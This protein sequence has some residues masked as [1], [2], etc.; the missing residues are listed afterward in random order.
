MDPTIQSLLDFGA[1]GAFAA[2]LVWMNNKL[3]KRQDQMVQDFSA[4]VME[5]EKAHQEAEE[6]IRNRYDE[7]IAR[8]EGRMNTLFDEMV[9]TLRAHSVVLEQIKDALERLD[10][11]E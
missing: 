9:S 6:N 1:V 4:K 5:Q 7:I 8:H 2:F 10:R 3:Q 11:R